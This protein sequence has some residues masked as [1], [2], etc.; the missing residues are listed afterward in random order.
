MGLVITTKGLIKQ[1]LKLTPRLRQG[2]LYQMLK[3][4]R[5]ET[6]Y[7]TML[8]CVKEL[9]NEGVLKT[10]I[11]IRGDDNWFNTYVERVE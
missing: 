11:A 1:A 3:T 9:E 4:I 10:S 2:S 8:Y 6:N 5:P 7:V